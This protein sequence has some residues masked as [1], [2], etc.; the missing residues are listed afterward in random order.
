MV[1]SGTA[2]GAARARSLLQQLRRSISDEAAQAAAAEGLERLARLGASQR[3]AITAAGGLEALLDCLRTNSSSPAHAAAVRTLLHLCGPN[4]ANQQRLAAGGGI[5][6]LML[7]LGTSD[8]AQLLS[9]AAG[10]LEMVCQNNATNCQRVIAAGGA[11]AV[12]RLLQLSSA[13]TQHFAAARLSVLVC[14]LPS[15]KALMLGAGAVP[16]LVAVLARGIDGEAQQSAAAALSNLAAEFS[17]AKQA[18]VQAGAIAT[19]VDRLRTSTTGEFLMPAARCLSHVAGDAAAKDAVI[20]AGG[21]EALLAALNGPAGRQPS[22]QAGVFSGLANLAAV[23]KRTKATIAAFGGVHAAAR[24]LRTSADALVQRNAALLLRNMGDDARDCTQQAFAESGA[25][26]ALLELL[27]TYPTSIAAEE[28]GIALYES[29]SRRAAHRQAACAAG[30]CAL[31]VGMLQHPAVT[32][33]ARHQAVQALRILIVGDQQ[34]AAVHAGDIPALLSCLRPNHSRRTQ[35]QAVEALKSLAVGNAEYRQPVAAAGAIPVLSD[36]L[37]SEDTQLAISAG[38][39]LRALALGCLTRAAAVARAFGFAQHEVAVMADVL[40]SDAMPKITLPGQILPPQ[41]TGPLAVAA[42]SQ[43]TPSQAGAVLCATPGCGNARGLRLCSGC[44]TVRY[45]S[46][47]CSKAHW[48]QHRQECRRIQAER[49]AASGAAASA[50][51]PQ[52]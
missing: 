25:V 34:H 14:D 20:A 45:C 7:H 33:G 24:L 39:A 47:A 37:H 41:P 26:P 21:I 23:S 11:S 29:V 50:S 36:L 42:V 40:A 9:D 17:P 18:A 10:M 28:G 52:S 15:S 16:A 38:G 6:V 2:P 4:S 46:E 30:G 35:L 44:G 43:L 3:Q 8:H 31:L 5:E 22:V 12:V 19:L 32:S 1:P 48:R 51:H 27:R 13:E 49:A